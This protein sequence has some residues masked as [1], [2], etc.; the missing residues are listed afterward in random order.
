MEWL[1]TRYI[2]GMSLSAIGPYC[3]ARA[4]AAQQQVEAGCLSFNDR[5]A[6]ETYMYLR[7]LQ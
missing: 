3:D 2:V 4:A 7:R 5:R 6:V 1:D